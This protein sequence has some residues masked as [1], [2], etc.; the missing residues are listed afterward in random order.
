M[1]MTMIAG[2][3]SESAVFY[4]AALNTGAAT[5]RAALASRV[6]SVVWFVVN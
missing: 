5:D 1:P 2:I 4:F 3:A 6:T